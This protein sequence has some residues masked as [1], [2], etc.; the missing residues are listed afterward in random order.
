MG[1]RIAMRMMRTVMAARISTMVMPASRRLISAL[2][3]L[4]PAAIAQNG[5]RR[6]RRQDQAVSRRR[7]PEAHRDFVLSR[8]D[9][10]RAEREVCAQDRR[11]DSV[12]LAVPAGILRVG[13]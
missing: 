6:E 13:D 5:R 3:P 8:G 7:R 10:D 9:G 1:T 11:A 12:H 4:L 2:Y